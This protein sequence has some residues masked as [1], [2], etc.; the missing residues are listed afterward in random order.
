M[1]KVFE[2]LF[3]REVR[4]TTVDSITKRFDAKSFFEA[5]VNLWRPSELITKIGGYHN[6]DIL[7]KDEE[8]FASLDK[9]L[10]ALLD[11][12]LVIDD[13]LGKEFLTGQ[14]IPH[15]RQLKED[16][17]WT[18]FNGWGVEQ[19]IYKEDRSGQVAGFQREEF[20]RFDPLK[21]LIH[22]KI[23]S[24]SG[25]FRDFEDGILPYGKFV[26]TTNGGTSYN[27]RGNPLAEKLIAPWFFRCTSDDL[28]ID[29]AKRF[30]NGFL[31]AAIED[32]E[33]KDA[34]KA[35]LENAGKSSIIVTDKNS[36]L[37]LAQP[38][39]DSSL[40]LQMAQEA[41][42]RI[43]KV[44]LGETQTSDMQE[45]G[46]SASASVHNEVR[47]EKTRADITLVEYALNETILQ[48]AL[49]NKIISNADERDKL[50]KA[51]L[52]YDPY[53]DM[54]T[55]QRDSILSTVGVK[56]TKKYFIENYGFK[57]DDFD[58]V[59]T[60]Q[61]SFFKLQD[62]PK[63]RSFLSSHDVKSYLDNG[64]CCP[65]HNLENVG[66]KE[67]RINDEIDEIIGLLDRN[68]SA[69]INEED[70]ISA[71]MTAENQQDLSNK[72]SALF[73]NRDSSFVDTMTEALYLSAARGAMVGNPEV[74]K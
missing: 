14:I 58:I 4:E 24:A 6:F 39:R 13:G 38:N 21:D 52:I 29:F 42:K 41:T 23:R 16:F 26:V 68:A 20:W 45:R 44:V 49:V 5:T 40:Y 71:I 2:G 64:S 61:N 15:E 8:I 27:P 34:V 32:I 43:Q 37:T 70:L 60:Q 33:Q 35:A 19:I 67:T 63:K 17:F 50:P 36:S 62:K 7:T 22:A 18:V 66:R 57:E 1:F 53:A 47:L 74:I 28:W 59:S 10:A 31:H 46:G 73:D 9:R 55:A 65:T 12:R 48:I 56:F 51:R 54:Q 25:D 30:A 3:K 11:T 72:L 69:P